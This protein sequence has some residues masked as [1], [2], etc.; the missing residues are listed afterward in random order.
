MLK[1]K[2]STWREQRVNVPGLQ[3]FQVDFIDTNPNYYLISNNSADVL[4]VSVS[5]G[6]GTAVYDIIVPSFGVKMFSRPLPGKF[7]YLYTPIA[8]GAVV[9]VQ[10]FEA[11]FNPT[12]IAQTQEVV[13]RGSAG[14]LGTVIVDTVTNPV[15]LGASAA[16]IGKV[17]INN[18][19][20]AASQ[21]VVL[22]PGVQQIIK[23]TPGYVFALTNAPGDI[24]VQNGAGTVFAGAYAAAHPFYNNADIRLTSAA[25]GTVYIVYK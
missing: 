9:M 2:Q 12:G 14:V 5:A 23:A 21:Q 25:G 19:A 11:E 13:S 17:D 7:L 6:L 10:S 20:V 4:Y 18:F 16:V 3:P 1:W 8:L 15:I 22:A 24:T